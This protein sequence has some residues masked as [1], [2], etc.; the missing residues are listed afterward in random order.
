MKSKAVSVPYL[1]WILV[2]TIIPLMLILVFAF[3]TDGGKFSLDAIRHVGF[4]A[5]VLLKSFRLAVISTV[6]CL[7]IGYPA[8]YLLTKL[9]AS[10][11]GT[12]VTLV[13]LPMWI[14]FLLRTYAWVNILGN[15]GMINKFFSLFGF[16]VQMINTEGAVVLGMVYNFLPFMILPLHSV[17]V[18]INQSVIEAAQ[19]LGANPLKVIK[20]VI[21]PLSVP[22]IVSGITM[23]FVPAVSTFIISRMLGGGSNILIG[24]IIEEQMVGAANNPYVGAA[25]SMLLMVVVLIFMGLLGKVEDEDKEGMLV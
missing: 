13:I 22:G 3:T 11:Q 18:K 8:A 2:F 20:N 4:F 16:Q 1:M 10:I 5:P 9:N 23:V 19:D 17:M 25:I 7:I 21:L 6:I 15:E 24:D 14:N 12:F